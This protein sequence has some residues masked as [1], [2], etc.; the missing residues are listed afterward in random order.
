ML[1]MAFIEVERCCL[2]GSMIVVG[3][4]RAAWVAVNKHAG[5]RAFSRADIGLSPLSGP[6]RGKRN[7]CQLL[8]PQ[9][10]SPHK[11]SRPPRPR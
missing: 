9:S 4:M 2:C 7:I 1:T 6:Q 11:V 8:R 10:T 3:S 5:T